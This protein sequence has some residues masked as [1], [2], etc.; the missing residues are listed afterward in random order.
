MITIRTACIPDSW[1]PDNDTAF[2]EWLN[3]IA[4]ERAKKYEV[5]FNT[6]D[7]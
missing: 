2:N 7:Y 5:E 3:K 1:N 4:T 6:Q